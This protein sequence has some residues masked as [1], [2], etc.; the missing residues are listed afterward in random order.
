MRGR[1]SSKINSMKYRRT[2]ITAINGWNLQGV[3]FSS[4]KTYI[5]PKKTG[6]PKKST[7][8]FVKSFKY[9]KNMDF[10]IISEK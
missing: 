9:V 2:T 4:I 8:K 7:Y 3:T 10:F 6:I 5:Q 1:M